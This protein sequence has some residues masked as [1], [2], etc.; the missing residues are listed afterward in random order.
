MTKT[1]RLTLDDALACKLEALADFHGESAP[2][3][4]RLLIRYGH[5]DMQRFVEAEFGPNDEKV[6]PRGPQPDDEIPM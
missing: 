4:P 5:F 2:D 3:T 1:I 6:P